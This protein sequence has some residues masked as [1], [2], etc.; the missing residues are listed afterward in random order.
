MDGEVEHPE[1]QAENALREAVRRIE[2]EAAGA[3]AYSEEQIRAAFSVPPYPQ[4]SNGP[5]CQ[6]PF[7]WS[8]RAES[9]MAGYWRGSACPVCGLATTHGDRKHQY[10]VYPDRTVLE[11]GP[12]FDQGIYRLLADAEETRLRQHRREIAESRSWHPGECTNCRL[13]DEPVKGPPGAE[14]CKWCDELRILAPAPAPPKPPERQ[15]RRRMDA[16]ERATVVS[17]LITLTGVA[18][19]MFGGWWPLGV[20]LWALG[21]L[22]GTRRR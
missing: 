19:V 7:H 2:N 18:I 15:Q 20:A 22:Y 14:L 12:D 8:I 10:T 6:C 5:D 11:P 13:T 21:L 9:A 4:C 17:L 3:V 1:Q 16:G